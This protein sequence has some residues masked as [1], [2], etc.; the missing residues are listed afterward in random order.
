MV[1]PN[2]VELCPNCGQ[3]ALRCYGQ[4]GTPATVA[5][6]CGNCGYQPP[7]PPKPE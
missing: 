1:Q 3:P 2:K 6:V 4:I 7:Q 5:K